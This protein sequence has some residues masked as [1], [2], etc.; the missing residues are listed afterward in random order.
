M[1]LLL[2]RVTKAS[3]TVDGK[4]VGEIDGGILALVG[5][6]QGDSEALFDGAIEKMINLRIFRDENGVMN[7][8]LLDAGGGILAVSQFTL[9][10]DARKGRRPSY[11]DAMPP[12]EAEA[13]FAKFVDRLREKFTGTVATGVFGAMMDVALVN[14]GPVTIWLDSA[15]MNWNKK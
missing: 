4:V 2:Q 8:S 12:A 14:D 3:V 13:L 6:G 5:L 15:E 10:A 7:R 1:R 9:Y 11:T